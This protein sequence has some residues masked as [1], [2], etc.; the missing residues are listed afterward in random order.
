MQKLIRSALALAFL[1]TAAEVA[2]AQIQ[3]PEENTN[4]GTASG[5]F[6]MLGAGARGMALGGSFTAMASDVEALYYNPAGL[7]LMEPGLQVMATAMPYFANT[8]YFW[9]GLAFPFSTGDYAI[10]LSLG[11]FGFGSAPVYTEEDPTNAR[12]QTYG[13]SQSFVALSFAHAF[14]DRF[15]GGLTL[16]YIQDRLGDASAQAFSIDVGTNFHTEFAGRPIAFAVVIQNLGS[17]LEH[18]GSGLD[19]NVFPTS[20][21]PDVPSANLDP[22][23]SRFRAQSFPLPTVFRVGLVYDVLSTASSRATLGGEFN[24]PNNTDPSWG[25]AGEYEWLPPDGPIGAALRGSYSFQPDNTLSAQE[26]LAIG[27]SLDVEDTG[28]DGL[29]IGAG[30]K[31]RFSNY[32][33]RMDYT[34]RHFGAL[35][36]INVFTLAFGIR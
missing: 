27:Q 2:S 7:P 8:N 35:G 10:G 20:D 23:P 36:S 29:A 5:E 21:D 17:Q 11:N 13:V 18:S 6:L 15:T 31:Y 12:D 14:I 24:E 22:A 30:L 16:K 25:F 28:L 32:E 34:Y 19:V 33:A 1:A 4:I 26:D 3:V 9:L